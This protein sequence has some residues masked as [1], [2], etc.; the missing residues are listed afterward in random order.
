[1]KTGSTAW[2]QAKAQEL[3]QE[4]RALREFTT[5]GR[6]LNLEDDMRDDFQRRYEDA[7]WHDRPTWEPQYRMDGLW[8][9]IAKQADEQ[10]KNMASDPFGYKVCECGKKKLVGHQCINPLT[11]QCDLQEHL[12]SFIG[13]VDIKVVMDHDLKYINPAN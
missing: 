6:M 11:G 7:I 3:K 1:M 9:Q 4:T 13:K 12:I 5:R 2:Y 8:Q 10:T